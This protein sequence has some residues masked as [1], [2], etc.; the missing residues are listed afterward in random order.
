MSFLVTV[1]YWNSVVTFL[2]TVSYW[3]T[4]VS[5]LVTVSYWNTL[6]SFLVTVSY[7]NTLVSF[8]VTVNYF[9]T[10]C[11]A[12]IDTLA[13]NFLHSVKSPVPFC[14]NIL[15][16]KSILAP[17]EKCKI[18]NKIAHFLFLLCAYQ[19]TKHSPK[20]SLCCTGGLLGSQTPVLF[21][22][23]NK[24]PSPPYQVTPIQ[25]QLCTH[26]SSL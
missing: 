20:D 23:C 13:K 5:F 3:N 19:H 8:L 2:V 21:V 16:T 7:W 25:H 6:V 9:A 22:E 11:G 24:C 17:I 1:S 15:A 18:A 10:L 12:Y 14:R 26:I 4:L